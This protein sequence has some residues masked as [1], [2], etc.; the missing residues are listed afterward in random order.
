MRK[1]ARTGRRPVLLPLI[2]C[3]RD[4]RLRYT[5]A[6]KMLTVRIPD[7]LLDEVDAL[8]ERLSMSRS[9]AVRYVLS[10]AVGQPA[11][12]QTLVTEALEVQHALA[13]RKQEIF[14]RVLRVYREELETALEAGG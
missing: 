8:S 9:S 2:R 3:E 5:R 11:T 10:R 1:Y 7:E 4:G 13:T 6:M 14:E 12:Q